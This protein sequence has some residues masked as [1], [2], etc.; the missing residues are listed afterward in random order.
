MNVA[1]GAFLAHSLLLPII[2]TPFLSLTLFLNFV[3]STLTIKFTSLLTICFAKINILF[4]YFLFALVN[5]GIPLWFR[6]FKGK[7]NPEAYKM[8]LIKEGISFCK[9]LF[10]GKNYHI[11]FLAD[12]WFPYI[13]ILSHIESIGCYYCIRSKSYFTISYYDN[14]NNLVTSHLRD[15]K[16]LKHSAKVLKDVFYT[17]KKFKTNIVISNSSNTN[18]L[19]YLV[20]NDAT[21][22]AIRNYSYRFGSI[23]TIFKSQ[24]SNRF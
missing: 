22:R 6:C 1:L 4:F 2:S 24:K 16:P 9:N 8:D 14:K 5:N 7:H 12:R 17:R 11:I 15:I 18:D 19:W 21:N 3:L 23:E 10:D 20:T 13:E